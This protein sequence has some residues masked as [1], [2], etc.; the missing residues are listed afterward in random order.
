M[1]YRTVQKNLFDPFKPGGRTARPGKRPVFKCVYYI[2]SDYTLLSKFLQLVCVCVGGGGGG[3]V[4][5]RQETPVGEKEKFFPPF[6]KGA[7]F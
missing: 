4:F 2:S 6:K 3:G 5:L 7:G 1:L